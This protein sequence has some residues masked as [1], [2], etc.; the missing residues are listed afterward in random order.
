MLLWVVVGDP[1]HGKNLP[2]LYILLFPYSNQ[3]L[4]TYPSRLTYNI[5]CMTIAENVDWLPLP[6][7]Q[8]TVNQSMNQLQ[9][10]VY[11]LYIQDTGEGFL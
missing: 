8:P 3:H 9:L 10:H 7:G 4:P 6:W 5:Y 2:I 1:S 11:N